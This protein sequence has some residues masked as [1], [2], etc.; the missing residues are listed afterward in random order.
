MPRGGRR[1]NT[2]KIDDEIRRT[3][4]DIITL[5]GI[6][7]ELRRRRL[8][9]KPAISRST[10]ARVC[11]GML[12]SVKKLQA[13][14]FDRNRED[15]K[16]ARRNYAQWVLE[17][18]LVA[19]DLIFVDESGFNL[20]TQRTRGRSR[21]GEKA[22]RVVGNQRGKNLTL[23]MGISPQLG[24][25]HAAF[26]EGGTG[27]EKFQSFLDD[28]SARVAERVPLGEN[29]KIFLVMDNAPCHKNCES[30]YEV[31][32]LPAYSPFLNPIESAFSCWKA[33]VKRGLALPHVQQNVNDRNAAAAAGHSLLSW[34][35][36]ILTN[37]GQEAL[38]EITPEKCS[39]WH[40][41]CI[42]YLPRCQ[43][44]IDIFW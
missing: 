40:R 41:H 13:C 24:I 20:W 38:T 3:I 7:E 6:G 16:E 21:V 36:Q 10:I 18:G 1:E 8:P 34:R 5:V 37:I 15:V 43:D 11:D 39:A 32:F 17:E 44:L 29:Q 22:V 33:A 12:Y 27:K 28:L 25:V 26:N 30:Q 9:N 42:T 4:E 19:A 2:V 31:K 23:L 35:R 14:L